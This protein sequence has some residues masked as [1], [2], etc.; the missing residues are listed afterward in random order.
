VT[1]CFVCTRRLH[2]GPPGTP[3][4]AHAQSPSDL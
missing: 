2:P 3:V 1:P 4:T